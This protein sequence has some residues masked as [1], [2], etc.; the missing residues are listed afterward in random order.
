MA[1]RRC[2]R[3][4]VEL[5]LLS[6][7]RFSTGCA[8]LYRLRGRR[9]SARVVGL[10]ITHAC[11]ARRAGLRVPLGVLFVTGY[12]IALPF[13]TKISLGRPLRILNVPEISA[14]SRNAGVRSRGPPC[15]RFMSAEPARPRDLLVYLTVVVGGALG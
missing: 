15:P 9:S 3:L 8:P 10:D 13:G 2:K 1:D 12:M 14:R 7:T 6:P 5:S 11:A 4:L